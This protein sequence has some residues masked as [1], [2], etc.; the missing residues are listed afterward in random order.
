MFD[1]PAIVLSFIGQ[2]FL[3]FGLWVHHM[4]ATG[5]PRLG[6]TFFEASSISIGIPSGT[7][8]FCWLATIASSRVRIAVPMLWIVAFFIIFILVGLSGLMLASVPIDLKVTDTYVL[9]SHI[10]LVLI[11]GAVAP[12]IG[13]AWFWFPKFTGRVLDN[14]LGVVQ[15]VLFLVGSLIT[16]SSMFVLG[17]SGMTRRVYTYPII[18]SWD[19]L[20]L[21]ASIGAWT[22]G[23]S[24]LLFVFN[25]LKS[26]FSNTIAPAN[27]Y[28]ASTLEWAISSSP[29]S[30]NFARIP[31][32]ES[33]SPL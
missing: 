2:G 5:L 16:F 22:I 19:I 15:W 27:P 26:L 29:P 20:N 18:V 8:I 14:R 24:F 33:R 17:V 10:H 9:P 12:L 31:V 4:Y 13:A 1:Y 23:L 32:V 11:G 21:I 25:L 7:M 3:S 28:D 30:Y 6:N